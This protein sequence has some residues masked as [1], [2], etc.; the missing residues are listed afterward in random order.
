MRTDIFYF[1][2]IFSLSKISTRVTQKGGGGKCKAGEG[3]KESGKG[4]EG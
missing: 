4:R 1:S 3:K 2:T